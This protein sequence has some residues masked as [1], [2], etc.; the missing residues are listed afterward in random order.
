MKYLETPID[1]RRGVPCSWCR[2]VP[3]LVFTAL[4]TMINLSVVSVA[5]HLSENNRSL[6]VSL[7]E[8]DGVDHAR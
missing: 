4:P 8:Q 2:V 3:S 7:F 1:Q 5:F 6:W